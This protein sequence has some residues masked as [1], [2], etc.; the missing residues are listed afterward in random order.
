MLPIKSSNSWQEK[1]A[2]SPVIKVIPSQSR[3]TC[4][5]IYTHIP[6]KVEEPAE[7]RIT[8]RLRTCIV[9]NIYTIL[10]H[11]ITFCRWRTGDP[12]LRIY[13]HLRYR[14][15]YLP[16]LHLDPRTS[17]WNSLGRIDLLW[18][19]ATERAFPIIAQRRDNPNAVGSLASITDFN[20]RNRF[21]DGNVFSG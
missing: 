4:F 10:F 14:P 11:G 5:R 7:I 1:I 8:S 20:D 9:G 12:P 18:P 3:V 17:F 2:D 15:E 16:R 21:V 13:H 6:I 19:T